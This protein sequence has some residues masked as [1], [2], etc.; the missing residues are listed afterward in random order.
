MKRFWPVLLAMGLIF[1]LMVGCSSTP[2]EPQESSAEEAVQSIAGIEDRE[3]LDKLAS[4]S[5][6]NKVAQLF[7][8]RPETIA[9][10]DGTI[11]LVDDIVR[12]GLSTHTP[13]GL[14]Y[15]ADNIETPEQT[16]AL[17]EETQ[18]VATE[19][20]G[21]PLF[22]AVDEE[23]GDV[24]RV[25]NNSAMGVLNV[26]DMSQIGARGDADKAYDAAAYI[27][28]YLLELGF[29]MDFAP[30][31]DIADGVGNTM[32]SRAFDSTAEGVTPMVVKQVQAFNDA[33]IFC[34]AKHF[35]GIGGASGDSHD[36]I[37]E[38]DETLEEMEESEFIPFKAAIEEGVPMVM[39]G[40]IACP[41]IT[42]DDTPASFSKDIVTGILREQLGFKGMIITDSLE[43]GGAEGVEDKDQGVKAIQAGCDLILLP[44]DYEQAYQGILDA[45]H[46]GDISEQEIDEHVARVV[47]AKIKL[48]NP[49]E[50]LEPAGANS[51][52]DEDDSSE[53]AKALLANLGVAEDSSV[54]IL[55]QAEWGNLFNYY[56]YEVTSWAQSFA[57]YPATRLKLS[58]IGDGE[59]LSQSFRD[60]AIV[61]SA[62]NALAELNI[63]SSTEQTDTPE[64]Y[65]ETRWTFV[66]EDGSE[67]F[68][69][70]PNGDVQIGN[71]GSIYHIDGNPTFATIEQ[72]AHSLG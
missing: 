61:M 55:P 13:A 11:T 36:F 38:N 60:P 59:T 41:E 40:H 33:R 14:C 7:I 39:V 49:S 24:S 3:V 23:G 31:A 6:E 47:S 18:T 46:S 34:S 67:I 4:M 42:G 66:H 17:L 72:A 57:E 43:M 68:F 25:A 27:C 15:F 19:A 64:I 10:D 51:T 58:Y 45:V 29:N 65:D 54:E 71:E 28:G 35:P 8:V 62:F 12:D 26:G 20:A 1:G 53:A 69:K 48:S 37:I 50:G 21:M 9:P 63:V 16:K 2:E 52:D 22:Q 5:L 70:F 56:D 30:V 44:A 32:G